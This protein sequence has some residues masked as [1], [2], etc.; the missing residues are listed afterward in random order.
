M[1]LTLYSLLKS[2]FFF[3]SSKQQPLVDKAVNKYTNILDSFASNFNVLQLSIFLKTRLLI[4]LT[5]YANSFLL[6]SFKYNLL[7]ME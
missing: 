5:H 7:K 3:L 6:L 2:A 1:L 4:K